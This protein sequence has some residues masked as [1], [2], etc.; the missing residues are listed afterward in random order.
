MSASWPESPVLPSVLPAPTPLPPRSVL[1][2]VAPVASATREQF[3]DLSL[4]P[5]ETSASFCSKLEKLLGF[6]HCWQGPSGALRTELSCVQRSHLVTQ[7]L[8]LSFLPKR[9]SSF[10]AKVSSGISKRVTL[11]PLSVGILPSSLPSFSVL[12]IE[13]RAL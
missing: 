1:R 8:V 9:L 4:S 7:T 10:A 11:I 5:Q 12:G 6:P 2:S 13:P 3:H